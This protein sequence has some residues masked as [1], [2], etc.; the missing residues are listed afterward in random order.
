MTVE[1]DALSSG[2]IYKKKKQAL[3]LSHYHLPTS[4]ILPLDVTVQVTKANIIFPY[5]QTTNRSSL[6]KMYSLTAQHIAT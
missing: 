6:G 2:V 1:G 4:Q 5:L 3:L